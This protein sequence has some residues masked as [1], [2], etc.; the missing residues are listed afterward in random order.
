M[1]GGYLWVS[2]QARVEKSRTH[3]HRSVDAAFA[4]LSRSLG[5]CFRWSRTLRRTRSCWWLGRGSKERM[6]PVLQPRIVR[7]GKNP[8]LLGRMA[9]SEAGGPPSGR[10]NGRGYTMGHARNSIGSTGSYLP[11]GAIPFPPP[12]QRDGSPHLLEGATHL[13]LTTRRFSPVE[14]ANPTESLKGKR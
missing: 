5:H 8:S 4:L 14:P 10:L 7:R 2:F 6:P 13:F 9:R 1:G 11:S 3:L 12:P